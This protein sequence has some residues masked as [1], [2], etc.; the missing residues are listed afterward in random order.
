MAD[1]VIGN[2]PW[3]RFNAMNRGMKKKFK[4]ECQVTQLLPRTKESSKFQTS[5][6][7]STYFLIIS[8]HLYMREKGKLA[9]VMP[10]GV[11]NGEH[12]QA[13]RDGNFL[14]S[15]SDMK[16]EMTKAWVFDSQVKNLFKIPS[17]VLFFKRRINNNQVLP[18]SIISFY[19]GVA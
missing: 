4:N 17:C 18:D 14:I 16:L 12:H 1:I 8:V 9:F 5:Q 3:L 19:R 11:I 6:D 10:Y 13:F 2:P 7:I 15:G